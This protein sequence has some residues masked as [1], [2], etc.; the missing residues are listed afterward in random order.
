MCRDNTNIYKYITSPCRETA[1]LLECVYVHMHTCMCVN[2]GRAGLRKG[3]NYICPVSLG[4]RNSDYN[5]FFLK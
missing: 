2:K 3:N 1:I 4:N 5:V